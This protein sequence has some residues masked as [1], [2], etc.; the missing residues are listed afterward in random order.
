[1]IPDHIKSYL[2]RRGVAFHTAPHAY[3][4]TAQETA[5]HLHVSGKR[6][7]KT[8]VLKRDGRY[9]MALVPANERIDL[10]A[11]GRALGGAVALA[12]ED[13]L[14]PLFPGCEPGAMPPLGGLF[15]LPVIADACLSRQPT[16][17]LNGG[18]HTDAIE[19]DWS[20]YAAAE[21]P[22]VIEH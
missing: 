20:A 14:A 19:L 10:D 1:M 9:V 8:V 5:A 12:T 15:G 11:L 3:D 13:E 7:G 6:F 16:I 4:V 2:D 17:A 22:R 18:T 21:R